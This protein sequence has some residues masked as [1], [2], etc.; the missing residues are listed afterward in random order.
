MADGIPVWINGNF[1][2]L[3]KIAAAV[4]AATA[5][6]VDLR[7]TLSNFMDRAGQDIVTIKGAVAQTNTRVESLPLLVLRQTLL[8]SDVSELKRARDVLLPEFRQAQAAIEDVRR[9]MTLVETRD[10][11]KTER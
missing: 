6:Y 1:W 7:A 2:S 5:A 8:E 3:M 11:T 10:A 4:A 9:R